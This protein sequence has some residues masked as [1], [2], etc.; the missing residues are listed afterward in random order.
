MTEIPLSGVGG[1]PSADLD[2]TGDVRRA[3]LA[4]VGDSPAAR[5]GEGHSFGADRWRRV[6]GVVEV[7]LELDPATRAAYLETLGRH[8]ED[9]RRRVL[10][11]L[12]SMGAIDSDDE[13][14]EAGG[15]E[16]A[17]ADEDRIGPWKLLRLLGRGG[18][19][20][21]FL[22]ERDDSEYERQAAVKV[23]SGGFDAPIVYQRFLSERQILAGFDHPNIAKLYDAGTS[24]DGRPYLV[25]EYIDGVPI[26]QY[27]YE[28][29]QTV[30]ERLELFK[31]VCRAVAYAHSN[32]VVHRDLKPSNILVTPDG[33]PKLL[34]FGI[35]KLLD[36]ENFPVALEQTRTVHRPMT[37][38]WASP[39][40]IRGESITTA[41]DVYA[42]GL[43]LYKLLT[44]QLPFSPQENAARVHGDHATQPTRPSRVIAESATGEPASAWASRD[45]KKVGRELRGDLDNVTLKALRLETH[46]R[47]P[48]TEA[49]VADIEHWERSEPVTATNDTF[50]YLLSRALLRNKLAISVAAL[51]VALVLGFS[52]LVSR[53]AASLADQ[54]EELREERDLAVKEKARADSVRTFLETFISSIQEKEDSGEELDFQGILASGVAELEGFSESDLSTRIDLLF[55]FAD[56]LADGNRDQLALQGLDMAQRLA[57]DSGAEAGICRILRLR[58]AIFSGNGDL[59]R[60]KEADH[61]AKRYGCNGLLSLEA[62]ESS[63]FSVALVN[64]DYAKARQIWKRA[65][66]RTSGS[67]S[68]ETHS[69][70]GVAPRISLFTHLLAVTGKHEE[71]R[72]LATS[73][74][75]RFFLSER[76]PAQHQAAFIST[77]ASHFS[78]IGDARSAAR[79]CDWGLEA[80]PMSL[81]G[82]KKWE[83]TGPHLTLSVC[84]LS[85]AEDGRLGQAR[86]AL[87]EAA[88]FCELRISQNPADL[89]A[90]YYQGLIR[91]ILF[92]YRLSEEPAADLDFAISR[93][94]EFEAEN[95]PVY[96]RN[97]LAMAYMHAGRLD[98][99]RP[100]VKELLE[101]GWRRADFFKL[102]TEHD[103]LPDPLPP[104]IEIDPTLP[105][106]IQAYLDEA[107]HVVLPWE[108]A[109]STTGV[110]QSPN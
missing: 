86:E 78:A 7:V 67:T 54:A 62:L 22:A 85:Y 44:G 73:L 92:K 59:A 81:K 63:G 18:M 43:L 8:D 75:R 69:F 48:S 98:D 88:E 82:Q 24:R 102:A 76:S 45:P 97:S 4:T 15:A 56:S 100:I 3:Q 42:L 96:V 10:K 52:F 39:E 99:A 5:D 27:C 9:L 25:M 70:G 35:A 65:F 68:T 107:K 37:P 13:L 32:L 16:P 80:I 84:G 20:A 58:V 36:P 87:R 6:S 33:E 21:V 26:D 38:N 109:A 79:V 31:K 77:F 23:I 41:T 105:E 29:L 103:V 49:L 60:V 106:P 17:P 83:R 64:G 53:Q 47:Y 40:Q 94:E 61:E 2:E 11:V 108:E 34:D 91:F 19:G 66:E 14:T 89:R 30:A 95:A 72:E 57:L 51:V 55:T 1:H 93:F 71:S 110:G 74:S 50:L 28:H 101:K 12:R 104:P 90:Y 46:L